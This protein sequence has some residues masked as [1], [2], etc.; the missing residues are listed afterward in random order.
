MK[1]KRFTEQQIIGVLKESEAGAKTK[2]LWRKHGIAE[3]TYY[4]WRAK[5][6]GWKRHFADA[7]MR[8][9]MRDFLA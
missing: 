2:D 4:N 6:A 3:P 7:P 5:S 9:D 8:S 1:R